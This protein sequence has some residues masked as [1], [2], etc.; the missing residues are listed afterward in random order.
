MM[1]ML[2]IFRDVEERR[3]VMLCLVIE[4]GREL[5]RRVGLGCAAEVS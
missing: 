5:R 2:S 4:G 3:V 1:R